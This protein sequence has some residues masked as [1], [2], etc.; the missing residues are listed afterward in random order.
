VRKFAPTARVELL[1]G[2]GHLAHE[3][4]PEFVAEALQRFAAATARSVA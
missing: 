1:P 2:L 4:K 3:E